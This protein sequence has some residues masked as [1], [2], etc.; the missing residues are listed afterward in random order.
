MGNILVLKTQGA[1]SIKE[2]NTVG[3]SCLITLYYFEILI[4]VVFQIWFYIGR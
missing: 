2:S 4:Q 3:A 1:V